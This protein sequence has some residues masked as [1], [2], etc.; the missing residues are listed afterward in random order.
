M[1]LHMHQSQY[2]VPPNRN[3]T[4]LN[5]NRIRVTSANSKVVVTHASPKDLAPLWYQFRFATSAPTKGQS[6]PCVL[7]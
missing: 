5:R 7:A 4:K 3:E 6:I 1:S 2:V